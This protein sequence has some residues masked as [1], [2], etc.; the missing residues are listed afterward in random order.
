MLTPT[1][2]GYIHVTPTAS[3]VLRALRCKAWA[4]H[5]EQPYAISGEPRFSEAKWRRLWG[6]QS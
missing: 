6:E 3:D 4:K 2:W 5:I 1:E